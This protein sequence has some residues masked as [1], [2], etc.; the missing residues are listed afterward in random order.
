[1][2]ESRSSSRWI[3]RHSTW[4]RITHWIGTVAF[5]LLIFTG[6]EILMV[7]P[8]LYWGETGNDLTPAFIELPISRNY[9]HGGWEKKAAFFTN[10][11]SPISAVR[12]YEIFN[13]NGWGRSLH[14][15]SAWLLVF[16]GLYYLIASTFSGYLKREIVPG[17]IS[18]GS[19]FKDLKEHLVKRVPQRTIDS[20][21]GPLQRTTYSIVLFLLFP[22]IILTGLTMSPAVTAACPFLLKI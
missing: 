12:T 16:T 14:F 22:V 7:H 4:L 1:M 5:L 10:K 20:K 21:Y 15:L 6:I 19:L 13:E 8:R 9:K 11:N 2:A 17:K 3:K 18:F